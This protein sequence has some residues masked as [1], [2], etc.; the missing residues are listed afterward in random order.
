[1]DIFEKRPDLK[2]PEYIASYQFAG[3]YTVTHPNGPFSEQDVAVA[4]IRETG[5]IT[6]AADLL[7]RSRRATETYIFNNHLLLALMEDLRNAFLD[8][9]QW[10]YMQEALNGDAAARQFFLKSLGA[11]RGF[12]SQNTP[13]LGRDIEPPAQIDVS[14]MS[15]EVLKELFIACQRP[16]TDQA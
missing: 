8:T 9:I 1:M 11:D 7:R 14:N 15:N 5:N 16:E 6:A 4:L 3:C 10:D 12:G 2:D 13:V